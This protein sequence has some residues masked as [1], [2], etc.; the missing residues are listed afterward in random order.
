MRSLAVALAVLCFSGALA[1]QTSQPAADIYGG[2]TAIKGQATGYF[3][4]EKV[5]LQWFFITPEGNGLYPLTV[6]AIY[7]NHPGLTESGK[8]Y[9][10][11]IEAKY[12]KEGDKD[13]IPA[14]ER[15]GNK[16]RDRLKA[17]GFT[18]IGP[19][20]YECAAP[21]LSAKNKYYLGNKVKGLP[22]NV[23]PYIATQNNI[24]APMR[25][26]VVHNIWS[27]MMADSKVGTA[28]FADVFDPKF[29]QAV[30]KMAKEEK[31][32]PEQAKW[33]LFAFVEQTDYMRGISQGHPHLGWAC[34][35]TNF[36]VPEGISE[37]FL[38]TKTKYPDPKMYSKYA[39]RDFL[40]A[41]YAQIEKLNEA[42][43]TNYTSWDS[44]GGWGAGTG[45][46][47]ENGKNIGPVNGAGK[48]EFPAISQDL[49]E[50]AEKLIRQFF[51]TV[52]QVRKKESPEILVSTN[53]FGGAYDYF[54]KGLVSEDGKQVYADVICCESAKNAPAYYEVLKKP[55]FVVSI[56]G[57]Q[58]PNDSPL[59]YRGK[60]KK[61]SYE[62]SVGD[63]IDK[64]DD[65]KK[66]P[67]K[68]IDNWKSRM[69]IQAEG[70]DFWWAKSP[71]LKIPYRTFTQFSS[72]IKFDS[73][74]GPVTDAIWPSRP[75]GS[76]DWLASDTFAVHS[77]YAFGYQE[78]KKRLKPG[79]E[80]WRFQPGATETQEGRADLYRKAA[81]DIV[82]AKASNGDY[83][84][85]GYNYWAWWD[86]SWLGIIWDEAFNCGFVTFN[87]NAY[88]GKEAVFEKGVDK[89]G[90]PIGGEKRPPHFTADKKGFGDFV[91]GATKVN[92]DVLDEVVKRARKE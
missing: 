36:D 65:P 34:A 23:M 37:S 62:E 2:S 21:D 20:S 15:W 41:K 80:L 49:N 69:I 12:R 67:D 84:F 53:N 77:H 56:F 90:Y 61:I 79:D 35:A 87:D 52:Y 66:N 44:A 50:F 14:R 51:K 29:A 85:V 54:I 1:A 75:W 57:P 32:P 33:V 42:W 3:H 31:V 16:V 18:G 58:A 26:G 47:D 68:S 81:M 74:A 28:M 70:V 4:M 9:T 38:G 11:V 76:M 72:A 19:Y 60:V 71:Q 92:R 83:I 89:D 64:T 8:N 5:G 48:K 22:D 24:Y 78:L 86:T 30:E 91:T 45:F 39:M 7:F 55:F 27:P 82:N 10:Q 73:V 46:L 59:G 6:A 25:G 17:W 13:T 40:K 63:K 43:G 88:D